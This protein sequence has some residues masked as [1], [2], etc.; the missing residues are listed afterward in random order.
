MAKQPLMILS[1][2]IIYNLHSYVS[3][4][5]AFVKP[6]FFGRE[7]RVNPYRDCLDESI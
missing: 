3:G 6:D 2:K 1:V 7:P 5:V 4:R